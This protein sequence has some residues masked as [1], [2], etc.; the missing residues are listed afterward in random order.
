MFER[1][2]WEVLKEQRARAAT[3]PLDILV[4]GPSDDGTPEYKARCK[5]KDELKKRGHNAAFSEELCVGPN[6]IRDPLRD[7]FLQAD[8]AH[9]IIMIYGSKGTQTERDA[10]LEYPDI[11]R[12][13]Y[14]LIEEE[15]WSNIQGS[16]VW[17]S[18]EEMERI[19]HVIKYK[20]M[21]LLEN[22]VME[23]CKE[24]DEL[25]KELYVKALKKRRL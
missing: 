21:E 6:A 10:I 7:E 22:K 19:S 12:K 18:W 17:K 20:G 13:A 16:V 14:I 5:I 4:W 3:F 2:A 23:I 9:A 15:V 1:Q 25:R 8:S 11:G 24:M